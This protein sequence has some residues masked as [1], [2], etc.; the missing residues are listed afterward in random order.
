MLGDAGTLGLPQL[1][2]GHASLP[3]GATAPAAARRADGLAAALLG[4]V[5]VNHRTVHDR[6]SGAEGRLGRDRS[7]IARL[8]G[9]DRAMPLSAG[10]LVHG[11]DVMSMFLLC[12]TEVVLDAILTHLRFGVF[13][14]HPSNKSVNT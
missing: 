5:G 3:M 12:L 6:M 14:L 2:G 7:R 4:H 11:F 8:N 1:A 13:N 9:V 10:V